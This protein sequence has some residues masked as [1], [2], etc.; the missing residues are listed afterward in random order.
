[1]F[2]VDMA[3]FAGLVA[4]GVFTGD[5]SPFPHAHVVTT[6]T[7]KTLRGP[8]GGMILST[9]EFGEYMDKGCPLVLGGPLGHCI[10]AKAVALT[11]ANTPAFKTYAAKI[12]QNAQAL[13]AALAAEGL[14]VVTG[15]TDNHL[16]LVD[17]SAL[18]LTGR[19]AAGALAECRVTLNKNAIPFDKES[20]L[21]TSGLRLGTPAVTTLG[22]G[23]AEMKVIAGIIGG[24][25]RGT[26]AGVVESGRNAGQPSKVNYVLDA[27]VK[28]K[29]VADVKALLAKH[30]V[31]PNLD[32][33][34]L[35]KHF[36][37]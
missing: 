7:H 35:Q 13:A 1:V 36:A 15:G 10:A 19:Q 3:H 14:T 8:R 34:F 24:V 28:T 23:A 16:M 12:V 2:M 25:L 26:K 33:A 21:T 27:A 37:A 9:V 4:G 22:M 20:P 18:G 32:L 29:A 6:T 5:A 11:E 30:P 31:Y 17:V